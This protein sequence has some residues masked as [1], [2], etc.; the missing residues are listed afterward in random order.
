MCGQVDLWPGLDI[1]TTKPNLILFVCAGVL[2]GMF[3]WLLWLLPLSS[4]F[5][6]W[7]DDQIM[8]I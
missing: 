4:L 2:W 6:G 1:Q 8:L 3:V 5:G 7:F